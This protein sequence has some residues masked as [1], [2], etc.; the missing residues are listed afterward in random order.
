M[1]G[2]ACATIGLVNER[3]HESLPDLMSLAG[4]S[5]LLMYSGMAFCNR[6]ALRSAWAVATAEP[7][8]DAQ[9]SL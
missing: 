4:E 2:A 5:A 8:S 1:P 6:L 9:S 3:E 7:C